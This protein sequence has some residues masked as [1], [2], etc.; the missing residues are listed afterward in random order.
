MEVLGLNREVVGQA[1][2]NTY[3]HFTPLDAN[4]IQSQAVE[5]AGEPVQFSLYY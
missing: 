5:L 2:K 3:M 1:I 4:V